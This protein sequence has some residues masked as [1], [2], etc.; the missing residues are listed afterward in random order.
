M[1]RKNL[2]TQSGDNKVALGIAAGLM[3]AGFLFLAVLSFRPANNGE[4]VAAI[5]P[6]SM[7]LEEITSSSYQ[8]SFTPMRTGWTDNIVIFRP[9]EGASLDELKS[10]GALVVVSAIMNGGCVFLTS[11]SNNKA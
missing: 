5:F 8:L 10:I 3:L 9:R 6:I 2:E 7:T 11:D 1:S 4:D